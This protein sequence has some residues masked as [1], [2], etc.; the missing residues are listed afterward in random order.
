MSEKQFVGNVKTV[1]TQYGEIIK[2]GIP[3]ADFDKYVKNGWLNLSLKK[4][5][6]GKYYMEVDTFEPKK[7]E[8]TF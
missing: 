3:Q 8:E 4:A 6:S 2:L 5:K 7:Q 1:P